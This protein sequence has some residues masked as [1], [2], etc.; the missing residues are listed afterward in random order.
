MGICTLNSTYQQLEGL[1]PGTLQREKAYLLDLSDPSGPA[2]S[3]SRP[4]AR[5][6]Q[7]SVDSCYGGLRE[8]VLSCPGHLRDPVARSEVT[9]Q[10]PAAFPCRTATAALGRY[11]DFGGPRRFFEPLISLKTP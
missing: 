11:E 3:C 4:A 2:V 1:Q 7:L 8:A 9:T 10:C 5:R 6:S